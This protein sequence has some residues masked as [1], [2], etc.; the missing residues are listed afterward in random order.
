MIYFDSAATSAVSPAAL[1]GFE[2]AVRD[3]GNPS[4]LHAM[5]D[6]AAR[7]MKDCRASLKAAFRSRDER[8]AVIFTASGSEANNLALMGTARAKE[9]F[10]GGRI[11]ISNT[12]HPSVENCARALENEGFCVIR[13]S[14]RGGAVSEDELLSS[15]TKDTFLISLMTVNNETGAVYDIP[16]L[17]RI[18]KAKNPDIIFHTDAVQ[19]FGKLDIPLV[20]AGVDLISASAHKIGGFKGVG[21]LYVSE[22]IKRQKSL[23]CVIYGGGQEDGYRSGT[24]NTPGIASFA[25][26]ANE[27]CSDIEK[28]LAHV[29]GLWSYV[30]EGAQNIGIKANTAPCPSPYILSL[31]LPGIKSNVMLNYLS[32]R[33]ICISSGSACSSHHPNISSALTAFGLSGTDADCTVRIS[34]SPTNTQEEAKALICA[35]EEGVKRLIRM[36]KR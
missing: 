7:L 9:H 33:G 2:R 25:Y 30:K 32:S 31:T 15:I 22:R 19:A 36:R 13:L 24:E 12:E 8:D 35:L 29:T 6:G 4:S 18:A 26:A 20:S 11:I 21:A 5:G 1:E 17:C 14:T 27:R 3:Y 34:F 16:G 23:S 10:K 28:N